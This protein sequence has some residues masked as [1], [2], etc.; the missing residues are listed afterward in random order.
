M[1]KLL[2]LPSFRESGLGAGAATFVVLL[3]YPFTVTSQPVPGPLPVPAAR[4]VAAETWVSLYGR[5]T[6]GSPTP[7]P[8][9]SCAHLP[10]CP[11]APFVVV[12]G[13][14]PLKQRFPYIC[15]PA[16]A[17]ASARFCRLRL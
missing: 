9:N 10:I 11:C 7:A 5:F 15:A 12:P 2:R 4:V 8:L 1:K 17:A 3:A 13:L 14:P 6:E 16:S